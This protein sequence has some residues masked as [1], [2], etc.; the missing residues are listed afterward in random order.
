MQGL[1]DFFL[2]TPEYSRK[3]ERGRSARS[4][5]GFGLMGRRADV[6]LRLAD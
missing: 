1:W 3:K 2:D 5:P 6:V 4:A